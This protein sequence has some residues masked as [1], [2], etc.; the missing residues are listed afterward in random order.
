MRGR[1]WEREEVRESEGEWEIDEG[2]EERKLG[3][4][5]REERGKADREEM[6][7]GE[8]GRVMNNEGEKEIREGKYEGRK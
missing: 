7:R 1:I 5:E 4:R 8:E 2:R 3:K 6:R